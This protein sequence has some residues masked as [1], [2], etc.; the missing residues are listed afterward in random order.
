MIHVMRDVLLSKI[1]VSHREGWV[2]EPA[3]NASSLSDI[4]VSVFA[5]PLQRP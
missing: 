5:C 3:E 2:T 1:S 4:S